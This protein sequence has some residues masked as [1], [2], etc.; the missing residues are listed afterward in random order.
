MISPKKSVRVLLAL[1]IVL[2]VAFFTRDWYV[3]Y[4]CG[5]V[6]QCLADSSYFQHYAKFAV[7]TIMTIIAFF[8]GKRCLCQ[9]D[10]RL[11]LLAS[12]LALCADFCLKILHNAV[13]LFEHSTDYTLLGICFFMVFQAVLIY[14]HT[15]TSDTDNSVPW[16]ICIPFAV[17]F[18]TNA[19]HLFGVF[20]SSMI[21]IVATYGAFLICSVIVAV[22]TPKVG[23]FP[24]WNAKLIKRGMILFFCCDACVGLS[25]AT[26]PDHSTQ[27]IVATVANNFVWY[28]YVPA[29]YCLVMSGLR[30]KTKDER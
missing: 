29:L 6:E 7:T 3:F 22:K 16:I 26:G 23:Y 19:L 14:R 8:V 1:V 28:F 12:V 13:K 11:L 15:R 2:F 27:E 24:E 10:R 9:R 20:E 21:P 18:I 30:R 4:K 17:M 25:L 5:A